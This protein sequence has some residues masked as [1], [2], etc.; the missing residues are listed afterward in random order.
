LDGGGSLIISGSDIGWD[1]ASPEHG[2]DQD[3]YNNYLKAVYVG[4]DALTHTFAG[5]AGDIYDGFSGIFDDSSG[6]YYDVDSPDMF[7]AT[8]GSRIVLD[9]DGNATLGAALTF[10][11]HFRLFYYGFP[12]ETVV[13]E[14]VR[15]QLL[16][17]AA[18]YL[19]AST[20]E[21]QYLPFVSSSSR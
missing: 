12:L 14:T 15:S 17:N 21:V 16:C 5:V 11:G 1:L 20:S 6:G 10:S 8:G 13:E 7:A 2:V 19:L 4:S 9:Y 18:N 3:F